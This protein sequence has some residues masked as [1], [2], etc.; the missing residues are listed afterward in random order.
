MIE[1]DT[2]IA[3]ARDPYRPKGKMPS[4][5]VGLKAFAC[6]EDPA[7]IVLVRRPPFYLCPVMLSKHVVGVYGQYRD[8]HFT[9]VSVYA[10]PHKPMD[11]T[12]RVVQEVVSQSRSPHVIVAGD[13]NAKH[14]A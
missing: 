9:I 11:T 2:D 12:L 6:E 10:S 1:T 13:F 14:R 4:L 8:S 5:P 7:A 3:V